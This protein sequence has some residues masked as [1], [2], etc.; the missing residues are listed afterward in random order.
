M[1]GPDFGVW[2]VGAIGRPA[3]I[4][5]ALFGIGQIALVQDFSAY[6]ADHPTVFSDVTLSIFHT[7]NLMRLRS[8]LARGG[9]GPVSI[10]LTV[11]LARHVTHSDVQ[12]RSRTHLA[13]EFD[14]VPPH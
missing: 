12:A 14:T 2:V 11:W 4:R 7:A 13:I 3:M 5:H 8:K 1:V 10:S 6:V 9:C